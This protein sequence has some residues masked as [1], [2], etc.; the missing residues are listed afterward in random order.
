MQLLRVKEP[1]C[2][3][4]LCYFLLFVLVARVFLVI[5]TSSITHYLH[6]HVTVG[7]G[8]RGGGLAFDYQSL[9]QNKQLNESGHYGF[10]GTSQ[11]YETV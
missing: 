1:N 5:V 8:Q 11:R 7:V 4:S 10:V 9:H 6:V 3:F 2:V